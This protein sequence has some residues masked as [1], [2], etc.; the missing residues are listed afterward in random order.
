MNQ[1]TPA[2]GQGW[3]CIKNKQDPEDQL[4]IWHSKTLPLPARLSQNTTE[5]IPQFSIFGIRVVHVT[6]WLYSCWDNCSGA[7]GFFQSRFDRGYQSP[8]FDQG[9]K[10]FKPSYVC[11]QELEKSI[12]AVWVT[13]QDESKSHWGD[14][15]SVGTSSHCQCWGH[16][17]ASESS[18]C[19]RLSLE[20]SHS[21][22]S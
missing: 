13:L 22:K 20:S 10:F 3:M 6:S 19:I 14:P 1:G 16:L 5:Y 8:G 11:I 18:T 2:Q 7:V 12:T 17:W 4:L 21:G 15:C 9:L